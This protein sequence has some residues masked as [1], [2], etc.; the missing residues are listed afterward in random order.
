MRVIRSDG[1]INDAYEK[2]ESVTKNLKALWE[3]LPAKGIPNPMNVD[4]RGIK[5]MVRRKR[6][7]T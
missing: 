7:D 3:S 1:S 5:A 6:D 2:R 4:H